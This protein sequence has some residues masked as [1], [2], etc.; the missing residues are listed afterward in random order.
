VKPGQKK[1]VVGA[2]IVLFIVLAFFALIVNWNNI[3]RRD[4][5]Q[6]LLQPLRTKF[7]E[8]TEDIEAFKMKKLLRQNRDLVFRKENFTQISNYQKYVTPNDPVVTQYLVSNS[9]ATNQQAYSSAVQWIWVSDQIL[10][11]K[12]EH[13]MLPSA[14]IQDTPNDPDNPLPGSIVSDCESQA[15]TLV[16]ILESIGISKTDVRVV[17]GEVN[18]SGEIGGHAWVQIYQ[19]NQWFELEPTSGPFWDEEDNKLVNN[20][21]FPFNYFKTHPYPVV[22]YWAFFNDAFYYNPNNQVKSPDLPSYWL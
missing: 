18:F 17:V 5:E 16:S 14:F 20:V 1:I 6:G 15:Y 2:A 21:G 9:I 4:D 22:E 8:V 19:N 7:I 11:N 12:P 3:F 13:W 10:H